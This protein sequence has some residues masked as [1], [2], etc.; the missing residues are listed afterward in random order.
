MGEGEELAI[1]APGAESRGE[2]IKMRR[3][4]SPSHKLMRTALLMLMANNTAADAAA[5][6]GYIS[7]CLKRAYCGSARDEA[8][9]TVLCTGK[10][11][12]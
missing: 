8:A 5:G 2:T 4:S 7:L 6:V 3:T 12:V 10:Y 1:R 9:G 11:V